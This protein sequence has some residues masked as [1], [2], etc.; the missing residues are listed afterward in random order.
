M[1]WSV[2]VINYYQLLEVKVKTGKKVKKICECEPTSIRLF[3]NRK[4]SL[5]WEY[6]LI[7]LINV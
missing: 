5:C 3:G 1:N 7:Q 4:F 6:S 2:N